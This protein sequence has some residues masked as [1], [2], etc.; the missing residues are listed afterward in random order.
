MNNFISGIQISLFNENHILAHIHF[1][2]HAS[3]WLKIIMKI[4]C[5]FVT[6]FLIF[7]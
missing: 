4:L 3:S 2:G 6:A 1:G 5:K 7:H